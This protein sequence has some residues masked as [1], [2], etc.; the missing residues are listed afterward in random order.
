MANLALITPW[1]PQASGIADYAFD[2]AIGLSQQ[3]AN[4]TVFTDQRTPPIP[5]HAVRVLHVSKFRG[6]DPY[7]RVIYQIGNDPRFHSAMIL[8]LAKYGGIVHLHDMVLHDLIAFYTCGQGN[9]HLYQQLLQYWYGKE[10][11][12]EFL[13]WNDANRTRFW[14]SDRVTEIPLFEPILRFAQGCIVHS[15]FAQ[16]SVNQRLP[17]LSCKVIPQVYRNTEVVR[18][19]ANAR[20]RIGVFGA[21]AP[22][23]HVDK[24][25]RAIAQ[26]VAKGADIELEIVGSIDPQCEALPKLATE[27]GLQ[28]R[29]T[30]HGQTAEAKFIRIMQSVDLCLALRYPTVGETPAVVSRTL[31]M[32]VPTI[33]NNVGW[34]AELP[35]VVRKVP[36]DG[37]VMQSELND[38]IAACA[39]CRLSSAGA[40]R[41]REICM[42][43]FRLC[44]GLRPLFADIG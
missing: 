14:Q 5:S 28:H 2:L 13:A 4:I 11:R 41:G 9:C 36:V 17:S 6:P 31:Q 43:Q 30:W 19:P 24:V 21:V 8:L 12:D 35:S 16:Q 32:G 3:G 25:L 34:Y 39:R 20:F 33:V 18:S 26:G 42:C 29:T 7:D 23:K 22:H 37:E 44:Q 38:L 15:R 1:P 40:P 10:T 27:L